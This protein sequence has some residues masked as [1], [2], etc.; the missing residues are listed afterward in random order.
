MPNAQP[1]LHILC[2]KIASGKS[3]LAAQLG[4]APG[5]VLISE[6]AWLDALFADA[7]QSLDDYVRCSGK[8]RRVM[9]PHVAAL[10]ETGLSVVLDFAANTPGQRRWLRTLAATP[11]VAHRLH[12]LD[13]SD[14][15]CL[16]RLRA[17]N[18]LGAH[19][20]TVSDAQ[21]HEFNR[22]FTP[23]TAEEGFTVLHYGD[24]RDVR[25]WDPA[26]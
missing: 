14:D 18:A 8:L 3:T 19:P 6:D 1:V 24:G 13:M 21:F 22:H 16:A 4:A 25:P 26:R 17:R 9:Q 2:G 20:F 5:A 11:G 15:A 12:F 10:L 23:P 7:L